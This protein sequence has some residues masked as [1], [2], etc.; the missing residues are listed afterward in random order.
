MIIHSVHTE[1][2]IA[3]FN[4]QCFNS[5]LFV[6]LEFDLK[7]LHT[8]VASIIYETIVKYILLNA[9]Y[10]LTILHSNIQLETYSIGN[11]NSQSC[12]FCNC[13]Q[14]GVKHTIYQYKNI[15]VEPLYRGHSA[16]GTPL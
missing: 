2:E 11:L 7:P 5:I 9:A 16:Y 13:W 1:K 12:L 6:A 3:I 4:I 10:C 15:L 8:T 14:S